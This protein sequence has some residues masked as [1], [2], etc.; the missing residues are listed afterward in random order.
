M[1]IFLEQISPTPLVL[2]RWKQFLK[3]R[4]QCGFIM[5]KNM[6]IKSK[7]SSDYCTNLS[8]LKPKT[9]MLMMCKQTEV[10]FEPLVT[11]FGPRAL[12]LGLNDFS[13]H[14]RAG[15]RCC[16]AIHWRKTRTRS[17]SFCSSSHDRHWADITKWLYQFL[18]KKKKKKKTPPESSFTHWFSV[19]KI[20]VWLYYRYAAQ[21]EE[22]YESG[23]HKE[24]RRRDLWA[25]SRHHHDISWTINPVR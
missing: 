6:N 14:P 20:Q 15:T 5:N 21:R 24:P 13:P 18:K 3:N 2:T 16:T 1:P 10:Q 7:L 19:P 22:R 11:G 8:E 17:R 12:C 23:L 25:S 9:V 4:N